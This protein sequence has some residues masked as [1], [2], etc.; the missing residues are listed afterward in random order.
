MAAKPRPGSAASP[1]CAGAMER[2]LSM[3]L[4]R[5]P[6]EETAQLGPRAQL[7]R[8]LEALG[9]LTAAG[10]LRV[11]S[12]APGS[13]G[14]SSCCLPGPFR[15][16]LWEESQ[17]STSRD[18]PKLLVAREDYELLV[19]EFDLRDGRCDAALLHGC[20]G[21]ALQKLAEDQGVRISFKSLRILSF[22]NNTSLLLINRSL[23]LRV[24][25]PAR[26]SGIP[27]LGCLSLP[28]PAQAADSIIDVQLCKRFLFVL[29]IFDTMDGM[30][31]AHVD[32]ALLRED[33]EQLEPASVS[34]FT[35]LKVSPDLDILVLVSSSNTAVA[36]NLHLYFRVSL[37]SPGCPGTH[38]V[39]QAGLE[40]RNPPASAAQVLGLKLS[41]VLVTLWALSVSDI[42]PPDPYTTR[43]NTTSQA[44]QHPGHL[45]CE[46]TLED[47]PIE[48]PSGI[49]EDDLVNSVHNMK[50]TKVS[51]QADRSWRAQLSSLNEPLRSSEPE[52][53]CCAPW[54]QGVLRL[55]SLGPGYHTHIVPNH[56]SIPGGVPH[57]QCAFPQKEHTKTIDPGRPW[58]T[59][60]LSE[61]E[62]PEP[63]ELTCLS[64]TGFTALFTWAVGTTSCTIVLWD[65]ETQSMQCFSLSQ[66]CT[67]VDISGDQQLCL[68][69][70]D[71]GLSLMLFGLTQEEFLNRLMLH[72][73]AST[74]D[75]LCHLNGWGRCSIPIHALEAGIENRQLDTVDFFLKSKENLTP[76]SKSSAPAEQ[77]RLSPPPYL[78]QVEDL[79][80]AL[81]LLCSAV[82]E[83]DSETH[84]KHFAEQLLHLTLSFLNKQVRELVH[85]EEL[86]EHLQKGVAILTSYINELRTFMIKFPWK[87]GDAIDEPDVNEDVLTV[88]EGQVWEE[89]SFE[90]VIADAILN[91]RI[92]E[93]QTFFRI[94]GHSA[95][96]LEELVRIGLDLA[97]DSLK[98]NNVE[99]ASRLLR[100]MGFS[101]E[102][103]LL[104][105]CFY[106]TDRNIRDFLVEILKEKKC[107]SEKERRTVDFVHQVETLYSG[108]FQG[109]AQMQAF[110]RYW[111]KEQDCLK[112]KSVLDTFLKCDKKDEFNEQDH[113][114]ALNWAHWWDRQTQECILLPRM[115]PEEY[116]AR[117]PEALWRHLTARHDWSS[118][119]LW[120]EEFQT[121]ET[122]SP[123]QSKWPPLSAA[124][125]EQNTCCNSHMKNK[126]L[127]KLAR[128]GIFLASELEDFELLLLRLSR[129]GGVMQGAL[130]VQRY[131]SLAGC[132]FHSQF[133][134]YCVE[135]GLQH[136]LY[137]YLDYHKLSPGN[138]PFLEKKELRE[139]H[140]WLGFLVQ[141]RQVSSNSTDPKLIFQASLANAQILIPTGQA[142]VS[143][144]LL[145]GHT[146]LALA[147]T[148]YAPGGVSQVIQNEDSENCLKRVDP[149]LL[150][151]AL[152]PYP[153]LKAALF[154]QCTAPS[155]LPSDITLYHLIQSLPPFDPSRLFGWQSA[156]TLAIGDTA[157]QLP[158]FSS[159]DLVNKYAV[160]ERLNHT[161]YLQHGRPSFAFGT[162]LV[163]EL[164]KSKTPKQLQSNA[165][166]IARHGILRPPPLLQAEVLSTFVML[167]YITSSRAFKSSSVSW[168]EMEATVLW[169]LKNC[170]HKRRIQQVGK[171]AYTL[172]LS[173]FS[174]PSVG[175]ACVCF[176][177]LLGLSSLKLRVDLKMANVIL[178]SKRRH[179]DARSSAIRESLAEK[180]S[181][182]ADDDRT[183]TEELLV[184]L[185]EGVWDS[186]EQQGF[187]RLSRESS[188]QWAFVLQFCM[189]HNRKRSVSYLRECAK[190]DD[191]LQF[192]VHSQLHNHL[193]EEVDSLLQYFSPVLQSHLKLASEKLSSGSTSADDS[194]LQELQKSKGETSDF[195]ELLHRGSAELASWRWL[196]AEAARHRVPIL[197]VLASCIQDKVAAE[198]M[199]HIK[200]SVEDHHWSL[201]DL[202][203][204]W[205]TVL[206]RRKSHTLIRGFQLF[207]KDSPLLLIME[208]Y[209]QC[210]FFKNYEKAKA[211]LVEF[212]E[213]LET[214][215]TAATRVL[216]TIPA[217]WMKD[218]VCF[219]LK[220]MPQQCETQYELGR[221][222]QLFVGTEQLFSDGPDVQK[223]C[224]LSQ[225]LKDTP[226]AISPAVISS[227]STENFQRECRSILEKLKADG[228]FAVARRVAELAAL[229]VDSL[230]I[231]QLTQEM[232]TL[233]HTQQWSLKQAR[234]DFW[235]KCHENFKKNSISNRAASSFFSSQA[236]VVSECPAERDSLEERHL[237]LTLAGH[238]LAQQ[239]PVPV[240][241]LE[242][243]EKWI[244]MCRISQH[245]CGGAEEEAKPNLS[246][247]VAAAELCCDSSAS[248]LSF[249]KLAALN[250]SKYL[251]LNGVPSKDTCENTLEPKEQESL[252]T[253]IGQ[254]L[255]G[256][257]VHEA[258]RVCQYFHFYSQDLVLVLH[259]RALA[260]TEAS[261]EDLHSEICA[262]LSS[263]ALPEDLESPSVPLR[264]VHSSWPGIHCMTGSALE[265][266]SAEV[267]GLCHHTSL[268]EAR[269]GAQ[270]SSL[271]SLSFAMAPPTDEVARSL[272]T[273]ISKC[274]HGKNY[275]RQVL[276]LY[277]LAKELG[278]SYEDVAAR[279]PEAMLRAI[280]ASRRPD[281]CR[282]AQ[283]FIN[284]QGL[285]PDTVAELV[286]EE[287][288]R[289]LLTP[290][291]GTGEKQPFN[292]AEESQ[293]FLQLTALCQDRTLVGMKLLD[294]IPSV[295]HGEL[296]CTTE[297]LI[298]AHHCF[299]F[300]CHMEG[301]IRVLQAARMLTD[302]HLAPNEE[303]GLVV[304]LLTGIGRYNEMTYI[305]DLL[306]QKHYFEVLMRKKLD[307]T[308]TLKTALLDYIKRCRP[309]DSEKHNMIAL[310]FSMCREIGENHE[311]AACIQL[312]LIESQPWEESLKDG[313]QLKQL[314]LKALTLMLDAAESYTKDS[315]VRQALHCNRLTKLITLQ[316]H[317][318]NSGQNTKLI[319]LG[320]QKL[321]DCIM[322]LPRFYQASIVAEAYDFVPD[323]AEV[324]YQQ[325]ILKGDFSYLEEFKQQ[326]LLRPN[327]FEDISK[328][329]KQHQ[330]TDR[331]TENL[332][333]FLSYCED[334]YLYYKLAY[335]HRF[336]EIVNMLLK[337]PQ[338]GCCLKDMLAG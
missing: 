275:C 14:G 330:P 111:I 168:V 206:T 173:S 259:C 114:I 197:S 239:E 142:S 195:F 63:T 276:C 8:E 86:D 232:Q 212:Q 135:H 301:I 250:T 186:V 248:E 141:C 337:D 234:L 169:I 146:L 336:F 255:D 91:N 95:Q 331:V 177:E 121:Q 196:L 230:V 166:L 302:N 2:V 20:C 94:T 100:N 204:I 143:S 294:K 252:N 332:K 137:V 89:L 10:S 312:K 193:P 223:L 148:M 260:S 214:L 23:I 205:R 291:E 78:R 4:V 35:S 167:R 183:A 128:R 120:M 61:Q 153:K 1:G 136:L 13:R 53:S 40:L 99:E 158:H 171:E 57:G 55:E 118:I 306:H 127:D 242:E 52:V 237:L 235:K 270:A 17:N 207:I 308:G 19:Y 164:I 155:A 190:A 131:K 172:G 43:S 328:K 150:K 25:F 116:K 219:L 261:M 58:K 284:T 147:T 123:Q 210:M 314:L 122:V 293:T 289:E 9:S 90:E 281:R 16:F 257:C 253:L 107:F 245:A 96:Q 225:V 201:E 30:H 106:T 59:V 44:A 231:E 246:Q 38:P 56:I 87:P 176:L 184:L 159:P 287:V 36:L 125:I 133:I 129:T 93:A 311:A 241:E 305:F 163:Q 154:P 65:L 277:E 326:K 307:P 126:I 209:E 32:L 317:F 233:T 102:D 278:C 162:F 215:D 224:L 85:T 75:A 191:W 180:L 316:I 134:L 103:E 33:S 187:D 324:L 273:L 247:Q 47:L 334:I 67:P 271:D 258:S 31:V 157:S 227:Y 200:I 27:V 98:K 140:P 7:H 160:V 295:P 62:L 130:P 109:N 83:S 279:D 84:S 329:Y 251:D 182:L 199:G 88:K 327:I 240:E 285:E 73:S 115:S 42:T 272:H 185:E 217:A 254:L 181:K 3:L 211:K 132:D 37:Y 244:W 49:D 269:N 174:N 310:C 188:S 218:Q 92:P 274:L 80:P 313:A 266:K 12:L 74:V 113:R 28:L 69:L 15:Q 283:V 243:L 149:Q 297:L 228:Q 236:P 165:N 179:E 76:S 117:S 222:L 34:S 21:R 11:L 288:T 304:R 256:G 300:T 145:E 77:Q 68:A 71:T 26:G 110:P 66:K 139:A 24:V 226:V 151:V 309:G 338:T 60:H 175:A 194:C 290:S 249:S 48:G 22:Y 138:C 221:L 263:A 264:K 170:F 198:A 112:Q 82:R 335:E 192:L 5:I 303:Y 156:N 203:V 216:P 97:F 45:L 319:N 39:D 322:T 144:V 189:L 286:A 299:T 292:P 104:K 108:H 318:L 124:I 178:G 18:K 296:S 72:G 41:I 220:L 79:T 208:M 321:M 282:Q 213:S 51:F 152:T 54:F 46:G 280:L 50:L 265:L 325:V 161:Y 29:N 333:K 6:A 119:S 262:L 105:I 298:L 81:D 315:C 64:V 70:T 267:T 323:W 202:S 238:W 268:C 101:V 320:H 229:P